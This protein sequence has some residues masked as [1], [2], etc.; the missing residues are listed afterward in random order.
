MSE[1]TKPTG[2]DLLRAPFPTH[3]I[4]KLPKPT[5]KQTEDV[6]ADFKKG[7]RCPLCSLW[8]HPDAVHLDYVGHAALTDRLLDADPNWTWEPLALKDGLPAYDSIGGLWIKLTVCGV[9]RLG[10][11]N[12]PDSDYKEIG[13]RDKECIGDALRNAAMRFGAALE[14]WHKGDLHVDDDAPPK[15]KDKNN[16]P[17]K[18][19]EREILTEGMLPEVVHGIRLEAKAIEGDFYTLSGKAATARWMAFEKDAGEAEV[20]LCWSLLNSETRSGIRKIQAANRAA[21]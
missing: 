16:T 12:A 18:S 20:D 15:T 19:V 13:S 2:L 1:T 5:K 21:A 10:Y 11:G 14:L 6:K 8:H 7:F 3:Q 17:N 4:G 9:T